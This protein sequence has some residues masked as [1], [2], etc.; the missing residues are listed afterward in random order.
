M[1]GVGC[2][3]S[4]EG[5]RVAEQ[6]RVEAWHAAAQELKAEMATE[7]RIEKDALHGLAS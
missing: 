4:G 7:N 5:E 2:A 3:E 1:R 6:G